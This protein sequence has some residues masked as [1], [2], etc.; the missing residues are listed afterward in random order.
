MPGIIGEIVLA[1]TL[2]G[3]IHLSPEGLSFLPSMDKKPKVKLVL[4][5]TRNFL[6]G[7]SIGSTSSQS[8]KKHFKDL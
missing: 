1:L 7:L 2:K 3:A 6:K 5:F 4:K 8:L